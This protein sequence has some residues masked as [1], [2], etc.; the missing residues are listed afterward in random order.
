M[1]ILTV[2]TLNTWKCDGDY[3][4]RLDAM[5]RGLRAWKPDILLLQEVFQ[6]DDGAYDTAARLADAL[7]LNPVS[8][9][10]RAKPRL[11][12]GRSIA[13]R[14]GLAILARWPVR[15]AQ[16][17]DLPAHPDDGD[18]IALRATVDTPAGP[19]TAVN[20]HL[21]HLKDQDTLRRRQ[22]VSIADWMASADPTVPVL[23]GGDFNAA[24][25]DR[26]TAWFVRESGLRVRAAPVIDDTGTPLGTLNPIDGKAI[27]EMQPAIDHLMLMGDAIRFDPPTATR[28]LDRPDAETGV[29]PSDH[30]GVLATVSLH[31]T[32]A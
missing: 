26:S 14:S 1:R 6:S 7:G 24:L 31:Q 27:A 30:A 19:L 22:L 9:P 23:L 3:P 16:R 20:T 11:V 15:D 8:V 13:S 32:D 28:I 18:R 2:A 4:A 25:F 29:Y 10:A 12:G 21:T 5:A 17:L